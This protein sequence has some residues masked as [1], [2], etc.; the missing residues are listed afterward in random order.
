[1]VILRKAS[2]D[3]GNFRQCNRWTDP[4]LTRYGIEAGKKDAYILAGATVS[5]G[6]ARIRVGNSTA[7]RW[8]H[9]AL[10]ML[11]QILYANRSQCHHFLPIGSDVL[12]FF[13]AHELIIVMV[14]LAGALVGVGAVHW[15]AL[16]RI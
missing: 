12:G 7:H 3:R 15:L 8:K 1:M 4:D 16:R 13:F 2:Y 9:S 11:H 10:G 5:P 14:L 6:K